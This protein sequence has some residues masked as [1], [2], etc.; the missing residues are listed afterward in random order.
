[1]PIFTQC[2]DALPAPAV[3]FSGLESSN[4]LRIKTVVRQDPRKRKVENI[5]KLRK[6]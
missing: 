6:K 2:K 4:G 5:A 1:M 3:I